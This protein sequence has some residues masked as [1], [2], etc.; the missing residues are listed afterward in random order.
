MR[1]TKDPFTR[2]NI[3]GYVIIHHVNGPF[4]PPF[5]QENLNKG[6]LYSIYTMKYSTVYNIDVTALTALS[7]L[8]KST[9]MWTD[10][11]KQLWGNL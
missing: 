10:R 2:W 6:Q 3:I 1:V 8:L 4:S 9:K 7:Q 5:T 11:G